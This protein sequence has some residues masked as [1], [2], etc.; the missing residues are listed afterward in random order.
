MAEDG[1]KQYEGMDVDADDEHE[2]MLKEMTSGNAGS[3]VFRRQM[4]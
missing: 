3:V 2:D 4:S 1:G